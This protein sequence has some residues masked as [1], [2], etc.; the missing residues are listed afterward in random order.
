[1][2]KCVKLFVKVQNLEIVD[3][4]ALMKLLKTVF[5]PSAKKACIKVSFN[6][7]EI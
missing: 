7:M 1:M 5:Q 2:K 3:Q 6:G 4:L